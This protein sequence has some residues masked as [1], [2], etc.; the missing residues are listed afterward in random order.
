MAH[1]FGREQVVK[2]DAALAQNDISATATAAKA[3]EDQGF[4]GVMSFEGANDPFI[5][6]AL[7]AS[8][9]EKID[10]I[11]AVAIAFARTPMTV[12]YMANDL[13]SLS[14]GRFILG[15]GSQIRPHI[16][17]RFSMPWTK[18]NARM[19]EFVQA[20][21]AIF[22][23]WNGGERL[24]FEG[25][26]YTH[27]L[28]SPFLSPPPNPHGA[29]PI[30]LA[31]FGPSM[32]SVVGEVADGWILH[33]M[34]SPDYIA[35]IAEPALQKGLDAAGRERSDVEIAAQTIAVV[36]ENDEQLERAKFGARA[37]IAFYGSTPAYRVFLDHHGWG[38]LQPELKEMTKQGQWAE[39]SAKIT[40][41]ML[42]TIAVCG[43][44]AEVAAKLR[45]RNAFAARTSLILYNEAG[46]DALT[47]IVRGVHGG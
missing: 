26:F 13:Q 32:I 47:D 40:D 36:G 33:P 8:A 15:L 7:A 45:A 46:S 29:P 22:K 43:A 30:F 41:E 44:P 16:E 37:Q 17:R 9:T 4:D 6:L 10:L 21:R 31:G 34:H 1:G 18:P 39:M 19:R 2:I 38:D 24:R 12:A 11:T 20:L 25:E 5:P 23:C 3:L 28:M 27:T 14:G 42:E 35:K